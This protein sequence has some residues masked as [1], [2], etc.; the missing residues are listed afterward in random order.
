MKKIVIYVVGG[1]AALLIIAALVLP[2]LLDPNRYKAQIVDAVRSKTGRDLTIGGDI[3]LSLF[4]FGIEL[5]ELTLSNPAGFT[6]DPFAGV[7]HA[8]LKADLLPLL[9]RELVV[10]EITIDGLALNLVRNASGRTNWEGLTGA[11][12]TPASAQQTE[13]TSNALKEVMLGNVAVHDASL[14]WKDLKTGDAYAIRKLNVETGPFTSGQPLDFRLSVELQYGKPSRQSL[15][16]VSARYQPQ[17]DGFSLDRFDVKLDDSHLTG[18]ASAKQGKALDWT[19]DLSLDQ[20]DADRY[21]PTSAGSA[22]A[23]TD[24]TAS[25]SDDSP[26]VM[27]RDMNGSGSLQI[28]KLKVKGIKVEGLALSLKMADGMITSGPNRAKLYGGTYE[29]ASSLDVRG[30]KA[31][32]RLDEKLA[33]INAGAL[34]KDF[35]ML[36]KFSGKGGVTVK[37]AAKGASPTDFT[38]SLDG[39][40]GL[41]L[42]DGKIQG[43]DLEKII[44]E[45]KQ[46]GAKV[47]GKPVPAETKPTDETL[48]SILAA[49]MT[50][51]NGTARSDDIRLEGS[52]LNATGA[53]SADLLRETLDYRL[54]VTVMTGEDKGL[55]VPVVVTGTFTKPSFGVDWKGLGKAVATKA[56]QKGVEKLRTRRQNR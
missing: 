40:I 27:L 16:D 8:R 53:G 4:P 23:G 22:A 30:S 32:I 28:G 37:A 38:R 51:Q 7:K 20:L 18:K 24:A 44:R 48:F 46:A 50:F 31:G 14:T 39:S 6:G 52:V 42:A 49:T 29:G 47:T 25:S 36:D 34:F 10:G 21:L 3:S 1:L 2:K 45:T 43:V 9:R 19:F 54:Q 12:E 17:P 41:Q 56:A 5:P 55:T 33:G 11:S 15:L 26:L 13:S 35:G